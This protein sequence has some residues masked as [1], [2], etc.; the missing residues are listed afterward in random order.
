[1]GAETWRCVN[2]GTIMEDMDP[3]NYKIA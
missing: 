2:C 1:M 3:D